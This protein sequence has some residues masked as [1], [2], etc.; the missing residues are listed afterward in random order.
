MN[1][2]VIFCTETNIN[3]KCITVSY[4]ISV[5][6]EYNTLTYVFAEATYK[7]KSHSLLEIC[8]TKLAVEKKNLKSHQ[9]LNR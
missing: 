4:L 2:D 5:K 3:L 8:L 7:M 6:R 1:N 9:K